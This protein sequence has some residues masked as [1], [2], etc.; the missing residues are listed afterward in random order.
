METTGASTGIVFLIYT[1]GNCVGSLFA[2]PASDV[3]GRRGGMVIGGTFIL[4]GSAIITAAKN[5]GYFLGG[6]VS[7]SICCLTVTQI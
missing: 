5:E 1:V 2:G 7:I 4:F 6:R 3:W